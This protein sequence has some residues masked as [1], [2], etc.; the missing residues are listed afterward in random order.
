MQTPAQHLQ[1]AEMRSQKY[2]FNPFAAF[3]FFLAFVAANGRAEAALLARYFA[4]KTQ[5]DQR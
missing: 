2:K 4:S 3:E 5:G 1:V